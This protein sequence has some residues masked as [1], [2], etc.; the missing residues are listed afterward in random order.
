MSHD[1]ST[2]HIYIG[3]TQQSPIGINIDD[4]NAIIQTGGGDVGTVCTSNNINKWAKNKPFR[5]TSPGVMTDTDRANA[6]WGL[7][8]PVVQSAGGNTM[9]V[10]GPKFVAATLDTNGNAY[11]ILKPRGL[12]GTAG[13]ANSEWF[14]L[15][16]FDGYYHTAQKPI[17]SNDIAGFNVLDVGNTITYNVQKTI[18]QA[19]G[20][21]TLSDLFTKLGIGGFYL[22]IGFRWGSSSSYT[23][24]YRTSSTTIGAWASGQTPTISVTFN[25]TDAPFSGASGNT[26]PRDFFIFAAKYT[27]TTSS[28]SI[29]SDQ[30]FYALPFNLKSDGYGSINISKAFPVTFTLKRIGVAALSSIAFSSYGSDATNYIKAISAGGS[31]YD[32][33]GSIQNTYGS[34]ALGFEARYTGSG[35]F[36]IDVTKIK[37]E[38]DVNAYDWATTGTGHGTGQRSISS[39]MIAST[40]GG[41][42]STPSGNAFS[43]PSNGSIFVVLRVA[44]FLGYQSNSNTRHAVTTNSGK[45]LVPFHLTYDGIDWADPFINL[46]SSTV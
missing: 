19:T 18:S 6:L 44:D 20:S 43:V 34:F 24:F 41:T 32:I 3:G 26:N 13:N 10:Q 21:I 29:P 17:N 46:K 12:A 2:G 8:S 42:L 7:G 22:G 27:Y 15:L 1:T 16:D 39:C 9:A 45:E 36:P 30:E 23:Y 31:Y 35:T 25:K 11:E 33:T 37:L 38:A 28:S 5:N 14:R 4:V 40:E